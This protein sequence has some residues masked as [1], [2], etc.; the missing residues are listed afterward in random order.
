MSLDCHV[1]VHGHKSSC[2]HANTPA[3]SGRI[4]LYASKGFSSTQ[5]DSFVT[6]FRFLIGHPHHGNAF[7]RAQG[8]AV[9]ASYT[10]ALI[11]ESHVV[12][13]ADGL[14]RASIH[15]G[16][17]SGAARFVHHRGEIGRVDH[18]RGTELPGMPDHRATAGTAVTDEL[19]SVDKIIGIL[20]QTG[21]IAGLFRMGGTGC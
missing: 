18:C 12:L 6:Q 2:T 16:A 9:A 1:I 10:T 7:N 4:S 17:A 19:Q 8:C 14:H 20:Y 15:T 3:P 21:F 5:A 11:D 13:Q